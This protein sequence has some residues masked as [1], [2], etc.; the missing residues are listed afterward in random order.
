M[1]KNIFSG[2]ETSTS[3]RIGWALMNKKCFKGILELR[4]GKWGKT[5]QQVAREMPWWLGPFDRTQGV[6]R[7]RKRKRLFFFF[8]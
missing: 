8:F 4:W 1:I 3:S 6:G 2:K 7:V 5:V